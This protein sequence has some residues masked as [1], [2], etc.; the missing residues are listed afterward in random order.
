MQMELHPDKQVR[1]MKRLSDTRWACRYE[2]VD[3]TCCTYDSILA[4][5]EKI[6]DGDEKSKAIEANGILLQIRTY[7]FLFL[8][9]VFWRILSCTKMLSDQLQC[10][11]IDMS[12][13]AELVTATMWQL[14]VN[15]EVTNIGGMKFLSIQMKLQIYMTLKLCHLSSKDVNEFYQ[16]GWK[17][18]LCL[19]QQE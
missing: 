7:K 14:Y 17:A 16:S 13:A 10:K 4:C 12:K 5:L 18:V 19:K 11:D 2:A 9:I 3:T 8:L 1:Q 15:L 6:V